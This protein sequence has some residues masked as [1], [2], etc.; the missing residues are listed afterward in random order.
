MVLGGAAAFV[1]AVRVRTA[2]LCVCVWA[3]SVSAAR[4]F[5]LVGGHHHGD[6][7]VASSHAL[8]HRAFV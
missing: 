3:D 7:V 6:D 4:H 2:A 8:E 5:L 1:E